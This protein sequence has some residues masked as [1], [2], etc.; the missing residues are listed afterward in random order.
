[1]VLRGKYQAKESA[2]GPPSSRGSTK[3]IVF[4]ETHMEAVQK[5]KEEIFRKRQMELQAKLERK[6]AKRRVLTDSGW[7]Y[8]PKR[9]LETK[10]KIPKVIEAKRATIETDEDRPEW[11]S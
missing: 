7:T 6:E 1:M 9:A 3:R 4:G 2:R 5:R 11:V 10:I 8:T